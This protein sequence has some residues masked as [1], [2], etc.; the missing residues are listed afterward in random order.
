MKTTVQTTKKNARKYDIAQKTL[1]Y[2]LANTR[3]ARHGFG[4]Y[5]ST[6][7]KSASGT[8]T[9][10]RTLAAEIERM[11]LPGLEKMNLTLVADIQ[12]SAHHKE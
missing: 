10:A 3:I 7:F 12:A 1:I 6:F 11:P 8:S 9:C 5:V 4:K 2:Q